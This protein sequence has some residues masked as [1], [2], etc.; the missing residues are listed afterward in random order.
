MVDLT[1]AEKDERGALLQLRVTDTGIGIRAEL[2]EKIFE[3]FF[4]G[5]TPGHI[6]N[7]GTGIG[8]AITREFVEMHGGTIR[9]ESALDKGS[10]FTVLLPVTILPQLSTGPAA[11][12]MAGEAEAHLKGSLETAV[13]K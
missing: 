13:E 2:Q 7:Q 12:P 4:Q 1:V 6:R 9:V 5:E 3:S 8:L 11:P 10:C